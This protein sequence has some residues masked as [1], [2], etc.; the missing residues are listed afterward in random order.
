MDP[1]IIFNNVSFA[2]PEKDMVLKNIDLTIHSGEFLTII[3]HNGSGKST[4]AKMMNGLL[5]PSEGEVQVSGLD[6][7]NSSEI[8]KIRQT[9]GIVFQNPDNQFVA[10]TVYDDVA[11]GL[12]NMG[13]PR[14][15]MIQRIDLALQ[16]VSMT[17]FKDYEPHRLSGG[18]KQRVAIAGIL[19]MRPKVI[20]FDES[21]SMLDPMGRKEL[22]ATTKALHDEGFTIV[23]ITHDLEESLQADRVIVMDHG[24]I[25]LQG[26]PQEVFQHIDKLKN[27]KL[28]VPFSVE[29]A[30][31]LR[32]KG[33][34][35]P[36]GIWQREELVECLWKLL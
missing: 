5:L 36:E 21:T 6:T 27:R 17:S 24:E 29:M 13:L 32:E 25:A 15:E 18:Q 14:E 26:S 12:E 7:K 1:L 35:V 34:P 4:L 20:V 10:P 9:V 31:R 3:G 30:H 8:W 2:Y 16:Q 19:A 11:F 28:D 33:V 22:L 23:G